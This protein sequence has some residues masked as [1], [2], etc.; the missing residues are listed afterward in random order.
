MSFESEAE[1]QIVFISHPT[2]GNV[3]R[4]NG[5]FL[6]NEEGDSLCAPAGGQPSF[7]PSM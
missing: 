2:A 1:L 6:V 5:V 4:P 3:L 7:T